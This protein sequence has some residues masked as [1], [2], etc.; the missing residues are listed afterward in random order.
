M[1]A[2]LAIAPE[3]LADLE[4]AYA[5]YEA[6][7]FGRGEDFLERVEASIQ[8]ILR[9]PRNAFPTLSTLPTSTGTPFPIRDLLRVP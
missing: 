8:A 6:Q 1:A 3:A 2:S 5:Y 7:R 4:A 9:F